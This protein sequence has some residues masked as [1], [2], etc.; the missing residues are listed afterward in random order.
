M[1]GNFWLTASRVVSVGSGMI[2]TIAFANLLS[3]EVFGTYKYVIA[4]A[5]FFTAFSL[6]G[7]SLALSKS[8]A[9]GKQDIV[10]SLFGTSVKWSIPAS[11]AAL[12]AALYYFYKGNVELGTGLALIAA[13]TP[14]L[15]GFGL[16][17]GLLSGKGDFKS[18]AV[19]SIPRNI[20]PIIALVT[21]L[22][23]TKSTIAIV[24]VYFISNFIAGWA[25]YAWSLH[26]Y[27]I[28]NSQDGVKETVEYSKHLSFLALFIQASSQIDLLL[29]WHFTGPAELAIYTFAL[30]PVREMRNFSENFFP[31][32][33]PKYATKTVEEIRMSM[34]LRLRQM[35]LVSIA[36]AAVYILAA[37]LI[38]KIFFPQYLASVF[39]SQL[40]ALA[41]VLQPKGLIETMF[42]AQGEIKKRY[43]VVILTNVTKIAL[44][45]VLIPTHGILGAVI[46][47]IATEIVSTII[48]YIAYKKK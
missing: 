11:I 21:T 29:L 23:V 35:G 4:I 45:C 18:L 28:G 26:K 15:N 44:L 19:W 3:K 42:L 9:Q 24:V 27:K 20:I 22:L 32:I 34:G 39:L 16:Y 25:T 2:L 6:S 38:F 1:K 17:K 7:L 12:L 33:F 30:A 36:I 14:F 13:C 40:L 47:S 37:P 5:G 10:R 48:M 8:V 43:T 41:I 46:G 31:I